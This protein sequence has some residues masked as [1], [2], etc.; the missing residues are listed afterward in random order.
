MACIMPSLASFM[1][2]SSVVAFTLSPA[3]TRFHVNRNGEY[4]SPWRFGSVP[5]GVQDELNSEADATSSSSEIEPNEKE[6]VLGAPSTG[7]TDPREKEFILISDSTGLTVQTA[8]SK[9]LSQFNWSDDECLLTDDGEICKI[10]RTVHSFVRTEEAVLGIVQKAKQNSAMAAFTFADP[11]LR[12]RTATI[13]E[14]LGVPFVDLM[15]PMLLRMTDFLK[16]APAGTPRFRVSLNADYFRRVDAVEFTLKADDGQ[17]PWLLKE[18]DVV[19]VGVSR[20][21]KTPLSVVLSQMMGWKVGNVPLVLEVAAPKQLLNT[22]EIDSR[23]VFCLTINPKELKRIR[24]TRLQ[25]RGVKE[26]EDRIVSKVNAGMSKS[27]YADRNYMLRDLQS[28]RNLCKAQNWTEIDVTGRAIEETAVLIS[29]L[30]SE[31]NAFDTLQD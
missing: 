21:G 12:A 17:A 18:A 6:Y 2:L 22:T 28:A 26:Q 9:C 15:G 10:K 7:G 23:R 5:D 11:D 31:R 16:L 27:N 8:M 14:K 25:M 13:C 30:I 3:Q 4:T 29:E 19:I 20:T 1:L 24:E